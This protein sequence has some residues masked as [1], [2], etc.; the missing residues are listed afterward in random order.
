MK[1]VP[2]PISFDST[3]SYCIDADILAVA[4]EAVASIIYILLFLFV[5]ETI[6]AV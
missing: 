5:V 3:V 2:P 6:C 1:F 4:K